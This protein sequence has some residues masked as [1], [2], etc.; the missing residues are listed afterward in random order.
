MQLPPE[1]L[2]QIENVIYVNE[3]YDRRMATTMKTLVST[4]S[5]P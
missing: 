1:L 2:E 3:D 4:S 5:R